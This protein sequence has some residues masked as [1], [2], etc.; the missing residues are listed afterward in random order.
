MSPFIRWLAFIL[1]VQS[2]EPSL[3]NHGARGRRHPRLGP[4]PLSSLLG[5]GRTDG[6][7]NVVGVAND[8]DERRQKSDDAI[9]KIRELIERFG[10]R[11]TLDNPR[12]A[13]RYI[14]SELHLLV[15]DA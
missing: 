13:E 8:L 11:L 1:N 14:K 4:Q 2:S 7:E 6:R 3:W 9:N 15:R 5:R 10:Q 12:L